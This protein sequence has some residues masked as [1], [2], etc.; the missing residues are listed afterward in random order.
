MTTPD[1]TTSPVNNRQDNDEEKVTGSI[2]TPPND[3]QGIEKSN[4]DANG[5]A[6]PDSEPKRT[7]TGVKVKPI[8]LLE[9][10]EAR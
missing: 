10:L 9:Y 6:G 1:E 4:G 8:H 5:V 2:A 7:V 3:V